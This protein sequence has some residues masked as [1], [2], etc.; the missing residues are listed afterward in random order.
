MSAAEAEGYEIYR[1][2]RYAY[3]SGH[4]SEAC[5]LY[6]SAA[7]IIIGRNLEPMLKN[8]KAKGLG[9]ESLINTH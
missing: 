6:S 1:H 7:F 3:H 4:L 2:Y 5:A 8:F 9:E